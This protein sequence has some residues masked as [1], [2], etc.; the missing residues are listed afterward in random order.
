MG[1]DG[2]GR[3]LK[4]LET[5]LEIVD[6]IQEYDGLALD[7][8]AEMTGLARSTVH[9]YVKTL[10]ESGY[11]T[12]QDDTYTLGMAFLDKGGY[13]RIRDP[14]FRTAI[15]KVKEA[16]EETGERAQL[17]VEEHGLGT[18]IHTAIGN[19]AVEIDSRIGKRVNLHASSAGKSI[20][21]H[22]SE[23]R[24]NEI[25]DHHGLPELTENTITD[26]KA[27]FDELE[28]I[29][30][31]G[32]AVSDEESIPGLRAVGAP[33]LANE[34]VVGGISISG[35]AHR[36]KGEKIQSTLPNFLLGVTNEL[37]L[38]LEYQ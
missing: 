10:E 12:K 18:Y 6:I 23:S 27:L 9:G 36:M 2:S 14:Q 33:V 31:Q 34:A 8:I 37:Q 16:A 28:A 30:D 3:A 11:I 4:T 21:A 24:V 15:P 29:R 38:R 7:E 17:I 35:P 22:L 20:L 19:N 25:I 1:K 32:Y 5:A 26:K 13:V